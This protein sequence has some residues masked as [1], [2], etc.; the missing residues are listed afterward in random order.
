METEHA[1]ISFANRKFQIKALDWA[2]TDVE[3]SVLMA[4]EEKFL[5]VGSILTFGTGVPD[6]EFVVAV[7]ADLFVGH[8]KQGEDMIGQVILS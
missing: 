4:D 2:T 7:V 1:I 6:D 8:P 3:K 5:S